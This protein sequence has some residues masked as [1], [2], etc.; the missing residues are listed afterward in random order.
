MCKLNKKPRSFGSLANDGLNQQEISPRSEGNKRI[1]AAIGQMQYEVTNLVEGIES[2]GTGLVKYDTLR[3]ISIPS[4]P[5]P[6]PRSKTLN[7][8]PPSGFLSRGVKQALYRLLE[9]ETSVRV[10]VSCNPTS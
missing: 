1:A 3:P 6:H 5:S 10:L 8:S 4:S 7:P 2:G 9:V